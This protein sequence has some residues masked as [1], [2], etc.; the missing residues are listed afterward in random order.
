MKSRTVAHGNKQTP[1]TYTIFSYG[2]I[3]HVTINL[4]LVK[5]L[6]MNSVLKSVDSKGLSFDTVVY[7]LFKTLNPTKKKRTQKKTTKIRKKNGNWIRFIFCT[8]TFDALLP[9]VVRRTIHNNTPLYRRDALII[10]ESRETSLSL[11]LFFVLFF[12][13][14]FF[15]FYYS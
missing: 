15:F 3:H 14:F 9:V 1:E 12:F 13:F 6:N 10:V 5:A 7:T 4:L 11:S 2:T 8:K